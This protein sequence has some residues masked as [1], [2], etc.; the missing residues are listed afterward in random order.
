MDLQTKLTMVEQERDNLK[1]KLAEAERTI[2]NMA[3]AAL[4]NHTPGPRE[5]VPGPLCPHCRSSNTVVRQADG[6]F[7]CGDCEYETRVR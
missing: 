6:V 3:R 7:K 4:V 5:A 1:V 2:E